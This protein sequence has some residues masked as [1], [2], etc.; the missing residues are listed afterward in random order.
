MEVNEC[1]VRFQLDSGADV[2]TIQKK[3]VRKEQVHKCSKTFRMFNKSSLTPL[4]ETL[5]EKYKK[6]TKTGEENKVKF[7]VVPNSFQSLLGLKTIQQLWL[8]TVNKDRFIDKV[9]A[10][11]TLGDLGEVSL[12]ADPSVK[13]KILPERKIP[14]ALKDRV[15]NDLNNLVDRGILVPVTKPTAWV[16]QMAVVQ[17]PN[18]KLII[19]LDPHPLNSA[20]QREHYN[21]P[22]FDDVLPNLKNARIFSKLDVQKSFW[23][24]RLDEQSSL[25]TTMIT[26][27]GRYRWARLPFGLN[28]SSEIFQR[29]LNEA[30]EGLDGTFTIANDIIIAGQG[31]TEEKSL[32]RQQVK[33]AESHRSMRG[34]KCYPQ[35]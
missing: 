24:I 26:P 12:A 14:I 1:E 29:K 25:L 13:P 5:A 28:V 9:E 35:C 23:H 17:K 27:Y 31:E 33:T 22:P 4:G 30:L 3:F 6:N 19:C 34:K 15:K 20:L 18:G 16:S 32:T 10:T 8:I 11:N 7:V 2:N 21:L